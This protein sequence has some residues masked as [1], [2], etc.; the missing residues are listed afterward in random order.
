MPIFPC[1]CFLVAIPDEIFAYL[2]IFNICN[3]ANEKA[4]KVVVMIA[5]KYTHAH[6]KMTSIYIPFCYTSC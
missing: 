5:K 3:S 2:N 1:A 4:D 6:N